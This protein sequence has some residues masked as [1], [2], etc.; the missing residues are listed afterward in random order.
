MAGAE[1]EGTEV[2]V[3]DCSVTEIRNK[4]SSPKHSTHYNT[5]LIS[6]TLT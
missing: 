3:R 5:Q 6:I 1:C 2:P 4:F